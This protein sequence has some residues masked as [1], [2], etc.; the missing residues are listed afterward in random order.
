MNK[1]LPIVVV[2]A[3]CNIANAVESHRYYREG[4]AGIPA[5]TAFGIGLIGAVGTGVANVNYPVHG[6]KRS[7]TGKVWYHNPYY[8]INKNGE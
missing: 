2:L 7:Y 5:G 6:Y 8:D 3:F 1:F 4:D